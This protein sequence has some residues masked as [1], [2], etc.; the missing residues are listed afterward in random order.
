MTDILYTQ[1]REPREPD[2][3]RLLEERRERE[4]EYR[5][6]RSEGMTRNHI[7]REAK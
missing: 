3:E 2:Y 5:I 6:R 7:F 1:E 4:A